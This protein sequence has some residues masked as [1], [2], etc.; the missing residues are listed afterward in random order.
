MLYVL[1]RHGPWLSAVVLGLCLIAGGLFFIVKAQATK[2]DITAELKL[3]QITTSADASIPGVL[4]QD[5]KTA[6]AQAEAI[7]GHTLGTWGPYTQL[8]R[9]DPRR[10]QYIDGVA[11]RS[12]LNLAVASYG[13]ADLATGA[14]VVTLVA[15]LANVLLAAP[16]LN[17]IAGAGVKRPA[18]AGPPKK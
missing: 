17:Y 3:E 10:A 2:A 12:A 16:G 5:A 11:L 18:A 6:R 1:R 9:D 7:K 14:G 4:V 13:V 8:A 15:G